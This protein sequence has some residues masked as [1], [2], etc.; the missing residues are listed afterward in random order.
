MKYED[1]DRMKAEILR[2]LLKLGG[3][4]THHPGEYHVTSLLHCPLRTW[5][6]RTLDI[7]SVPNATML[8]GTF[9][10][11]L[12]PKIMRH[13]PG[14]PDKAKYEVGCRHRVS[15]DITI[16][17]SADVLLDDTVYEYKFTGSRVDSKYGLPVSYYQQ[18]N[19]YCVMLS[20]P[21]Y[22]IVVI[23]RFADEMTEKSIGIV[24]GTRDDEAFKMLMDR[25]KTLDECVRTKRPPVD[26][27]PLHSWEC[28]NKF[29]RCQFYD[30][31]AARVEKEM[32]R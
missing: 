9:M 16:V 14:F 21:K 12:L 2:G 3:D 11:E 29:S 27:V 23:H 8:S 26:N 31:C 6:R 28:R 24:S 20:K 7:E 18:V 5:Y 1:D 25:A 22:K 19:A 30:V 32:K 17:G 15:D 4:H 10:H 13:V